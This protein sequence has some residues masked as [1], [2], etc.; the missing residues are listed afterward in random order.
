MKK[1][2]L[3]AATLAVAVLAVLAGP[4]QAAGLGPGSYVQ[5]G[6]VTQFD[7][8]DNEDTGTHNPFANVWR[9]LKGS[10]YITL[11]SGASWTDR[12]FDS[13]STSQAIHGMPH[14]V[15]DSLSLETTLRI[16]SFSG[17]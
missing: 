14:Y 7:S 4:A 5:S 9:D 6:L 16:M 2:S 11:Q 15:R 10:A 3:A 1:I 17:S 12:Y 8:I 13:T